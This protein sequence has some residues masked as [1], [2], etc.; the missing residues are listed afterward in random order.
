MNNRNRTASA[1]QSASAKFA[2]SEKH[3][4]Q[5]LKERKTREA[6]NIARTLELK[7]QRLKKEEL[8]K[9]ANAGKPPARKRT[10]VAKVG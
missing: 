10:P 3:S 6:A 9:V 4:T 7:A 1:R 8:D 2:A 5:F